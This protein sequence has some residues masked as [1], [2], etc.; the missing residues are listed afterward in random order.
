MDIILPIMPPAATF[1]VIVIVCAFLSAF[2][3]GLILRMGADY[4]VCIALMILFFVVACIPYVDYKQESIRESVFSQL[5]DDDSAQGI[6]QLTSEQYASLADAIVAWNYGDSS[7]DMIYIG[8]SSDG[9]PAFAHIAVT[10]DVSH[11]LDED[12][13]LHVEIVRG[14]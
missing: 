10:D 13:V 3:C 14:G 6:G 4:F 9:R 1:L 11:P 12:V 8:N 5:H 7:N 2:V